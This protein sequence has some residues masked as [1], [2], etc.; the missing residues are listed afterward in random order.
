MPKINNLILQFSTRNLDNKISDFS[1]PK[2]E[3]I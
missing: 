2:I 3:I 1:S